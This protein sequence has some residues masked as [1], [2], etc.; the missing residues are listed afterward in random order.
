MIHSAFDQWR[1]DV[2]ARVNSGLTDCLPGESVIP[3]TLH[4]AMH[5]AIKSPGKRIRGL[6]A[7]ASG[8]LFAGNIA[9]VIHGAVAIE[10][11]HAYS[12]IHDDLP[13]MDDDDLRRGQPTVH[14]AYDEA[15]ALLVGD[16]LQPLAYSVLA[17]QSN[18]LSSETRLLQIDLLSA[19]SGSSGMV[20]GQA[21]DLAQIGTTMSQS[22]LELMHSKKTG[23]LF[24]ASAEIG[25]ICGPEYNQSF[26]KQL[27]LYAQQIGLGFQV[28]DDILDAVSSTEILGKSAGKDLRDNKPTY[29]TLLGLKRAKQVANELAE[30]AEQTLRELPRRGGYLSDIAS[31]VF[32]RDY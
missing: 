30:L 3:K 29:V 22:E 27:K 14:A 6:I 20:G 25:A 21:I 13:S 1:S 4:Q 18:K 12:L 32:N 11:I 24:T 26:G 15:T 28:V 31:L 10:L 7:C 16:A 8:N 17:N 2:V 23:A 19:A 9:Q 5:Y